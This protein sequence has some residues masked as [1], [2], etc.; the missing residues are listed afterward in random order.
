MSRSILPNRPGNIWQGAALWPQSHSLFGLQMSGE[1]G[2]D[3]GGDGRQKLHGDADQLGQITRAELLLELRAGVDHRL[4]ADVEL[5][6]DPPIGF[7]LRQQRERLELP[8]REVG[9]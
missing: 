9:E 8:W 3:S 5:V 6:G 2:A 7:A 1:D 4:V